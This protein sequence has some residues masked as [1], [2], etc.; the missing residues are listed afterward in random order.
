M[1]ATIFLFRSK[2]SSIQLKNEF[3]VRSSW[4][5]LPEPLISREDLKELIESAPENL[6][7]L[8]GKSG[9]GKDDDV[10]WLPYWTETVTPMSD[11][12]FRLMG[13][14]AF[15][16]F[17]DRIPPWIRT[18]SSS[19]RDDLPDAETIPFDTPKQFFNADVTEDYYK[20]RL[21][22]W[23]EIATL[24]EAVGLINVGLA[25][26]GDFTKRISSW[27]ETATSSEAAKLI[28][29]GLATTDDFIDRVPTWIETATLFDAVHLIGMGFAT[30]G[31]FIDRIPFC[32]KQLTG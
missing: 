22:T 9:Y 30:L 23:I 4:K 1:F 7:D 21:P 28:R 18:A 5:S 16:D 27:V 31:N 26:K 3:G 12:S 32:L 13:L 14:A 17:R 2:K 15:D 24:S 29:L 19:S 6:A 20:D 10:E 11:E 25:S 8:L